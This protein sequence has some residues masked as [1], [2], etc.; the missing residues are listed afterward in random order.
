MKYRM[1]WLFVM[2]T[3][4]VVG[5]SGL[6][7]IPVILL[8]QAINGVLLP[9]I[10]FFIILCLND[11]SLIKENHRNGIPANIFLL[12]IQL[13]TTFLG[14]NNML[15]GLGGFFDWNPDLLFSYRVVLP[16]SALITIW[17]GRLIWKH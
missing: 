6:K 8:A 10:T 11:K 15:K 14:L 7:P 5:I 13:I 9:F 2:L 1:V 3:G 4:F 16:V 12:L 17:L